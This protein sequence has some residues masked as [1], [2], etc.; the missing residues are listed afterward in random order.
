MVKAKTTVKTI[1]DKLDPNAHLIA[2]IG[3]GYRRPCPG[4]CGAVEII[5]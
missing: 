4:V 5:S 1:A 3:R 2:G